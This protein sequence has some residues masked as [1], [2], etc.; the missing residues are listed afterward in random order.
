MK[1]GIIGGSGKAGRDIF[2]EAVKRGDV[3]TAIVRDAQKAEGVFGDYG[4]YLARDALRL[5][6]ADLASFDVVVDS[7][8]TTPSDAV[9]HVELAKHL[10]GLARTMRDAPRLVFVLGACSLGVGEGRRHLDDL[11]DQPGTASWIAIPEQQAREL[12]FLR[13]VDDVEWVGI[14]PSAD[15]V[16]GPADTP[17]LGSDTL[18]RGPDGASRVSTGTF[19][20]AVL[21]EIHNPRHRKERFTVRDEHC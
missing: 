8:G 12:A 11:Y 20:V 3:P 7:L 19:A 9:R 18:L 6:A 5:T 13:G 14:S 17:V 16:V 21:D 2:R 15:F 1:I 4:N 10:I